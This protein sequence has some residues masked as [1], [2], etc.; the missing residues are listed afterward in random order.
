[1]IKDYR[2]EK[3]D[4]GRT[5]ILNRSSLPIKLEHNR[6]WRTYPGGM[7]IDNWQKNSSPKDSNLPEEWVA[8]IVKAR[9]PGREHIKDEGLSI[10]KSSNIRL[11]K[12]IK[13]DPVF[14]L[15]ESHIKKHGISTAMLVKLLDAAERLTI[16]VHPDQLAA[17]KF[18]NSDFGKTEAWYVL[19]GRN[20]NGELPYVLFGFKPGITR[21]LWIDIF[22]RQ[23]IP[24]ML[25]CLHKIY[26]KPGEV[27]YIEGGLPHAIGPG[28][29]LIEIQE[30]TDYTLRTERTTPSDKPVPD[31]LCHQG[32]GFENLFD[33]FH[34]DDLSL[35]DTLKKYRIPPTIID[36]NEKYERQMLIGPPLTNIFS[37]EKVTIKSTYTG[38]T[39]NKFSSVIVL[40]GKGYVE[41]G[42]NKLPICKADT[43]FIPASIDILTWCANEQLELI[44]CYPPE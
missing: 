30:P 9:N 34:Y 28:C 41:S 18:F 44:F 42:E 10:I 12:K 24:K 11:L 6:V 16:Q 2:N 4:K 38:I 3:E 17:R 39:Y 36:K 35:V 43:L 14:Y 19:D 7:L 27:Y 40:S 32:I 8:S 37:M 23:D 5:K 25:D 15:G 21:K 33:C 1:M 20:V 31:E 29:F 22:N 13:E 26:V